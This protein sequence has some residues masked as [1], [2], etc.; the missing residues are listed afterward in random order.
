MN[1][2][3]SNCMFEWREEWGDFSFYAQV[4][5]LDQFLFCKPSLGLFMVSILTKF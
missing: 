5:P 1:H 2:R 3:D 4:M